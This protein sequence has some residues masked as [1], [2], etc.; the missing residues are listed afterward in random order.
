MISSTNIPAQSRV[1][2][3]TD[4][5]AGSSN[6]QNSTIYKIN[7][8]NINNVTS[9]TTGSQ[10][11]QIINNTSW[12]R[13]ILYPGFDQHFSP[14]I[15]LTPQLRTNLEIAQEWINKIKTAIKVYDQ[16][17]PITLGTV[18]IDADGAPN[19]GFGFENTKNLL[20]IISPHQYVGGLYGTTSINTSIEGLAKYASTNKPVFLEEGGTTAG[21][22]LLNVG[23][24]PRT[25][26]NYLLRSKEYLAGALN[27]Y[28]TY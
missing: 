23:A 15:T 3:T 20:D 12:I 4:G 8:S 10:S 16:N 14:Y 1:A 19:F 24:S 11:C 27:Q 6:V 25:T 2:F 18:Y 26:A 17:T 21:N 9:L 13:G 28:F 7:L 5:I 22:T